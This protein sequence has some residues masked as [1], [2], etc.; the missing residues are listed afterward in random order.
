MT[1]SL[2]AEAALRLH[3]M[4]AERGPDEQALRVYV[5]TGGCSGY[6][7]GM[8]LDAQNDSDQVYTIRGVQVVVDKESVEFVQ[9]AE[10]DFVDDMTSQGFRIQNPNATVTCGCGSSFR[11][12][13]D[14]GKP[15]SCDV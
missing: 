15:G 11:T 5:K 6:S 13:T 4:M 9:D 2:T 12:A 14:A 3:D 1:V 10:I 8:A 7:Y